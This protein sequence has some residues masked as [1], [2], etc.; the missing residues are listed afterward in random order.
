MNF[1]SAAVFL[2]LL[3]GDVTTYAV[4]DKEPKSHAVNR[5]ILPAFSDSSPV[6]ASGATLQ[7]ISD[8]FS[9]TEGPTADR[10]GNIYFTDQPNDKIWKYDVSGNLSIFMTG[11]GRSNGLDIDK[12]GNIISCADQNNELWSISPA[13]TTKVLFGNPEGNRLNGP[14][15]C[16]IHP[17]G[18]I[19]FTD[20]Y[21]KRKYW[22]HADQQPR[23]E[24]VYFWD[25]K[26]GKIKVV[27]SALRKPNGITGSKDGRQLYVADIGGNKTFRYTIAK[28]GSLT[29]KTLFVEQGSDGITL[30][31]KG[32][33]YLTGKGVT[34]YSPQGEKIEHIEVPSGW[35]ANLCF[36]GK[37]KD[38]LFITAS[39]S[40]YTLKMKVKGN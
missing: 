8:Q 10:K 21:Y 28:D 30:D 13:G 20:P 1:H 24:N 11:T 16:W 25:K 31:N 15:D 19:Y 6:I 14:N 37:N 22:T 26:S 33:L 40:V 17:S 36:G 5:N 34:V 12:S 39:E 29:E 3:T 9:F 2:L 32:N 4:N 23:K 38:L 18:K 27:D 7:K 35:T